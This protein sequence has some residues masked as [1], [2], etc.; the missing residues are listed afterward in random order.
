[1]ISFGT[2]YIFFIIPE[3]LMKIALKNKSSEFII[4]SL[5]INIIYFFIFNGLSSAPLVY[6]DE[7]EVTYH[8]AFNWRMLA[9]I[10][11]IISIMLGIIMLIMIYQNYLSKK[12]QKILLIV[13][14]GGCIFLV[15]GVVTWT[16]IQKNQTLVIMKEQYSN[17]VSDY[18]DDLL[19][20]LVNH[21]DNIKSVKFAVVPD[22]D[23]TLADTNV[24]DKDSSNL[25]SYVALIEVN[26]KKISNSNY[27]KIIMENDLNEEK[28]EIANKYGITLHCNK[29]SMQQSMDKFSIN[30]VAWNKEQI[31]EHMRY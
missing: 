30:E 16:S 19:N 18:E 5:I 31:L 21:S 7:G 1:M 11:L 17:N 27:D 29:N 13:T 4:V 24:C 14:V 26:G 23:I 22:S 3:I 6:D 10:C 2:L 25:D 20:E 28:W 9:V 8:Y 15:S 12:V